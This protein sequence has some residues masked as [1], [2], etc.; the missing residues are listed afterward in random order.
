MKT[1]LLLIMMLSN[2]G[3]WL[4]G[5]EGRVSVLWTAKSAAVPSELIWELKLG[6]TRLDGARVAIGPNDSPVVKIICPE[7]RAK[8][9]LQWNWRLVQ[10][11][12]GREIEKGSEKITAYPATLTGAWAELLKDKRIIVIDRPAGIPA[13]LQLAKIKFTRLD[14][15]AKLQTAVADIILVGPD[16]F[17]AKLFEQDSLQAHL[18][19]GTAVAVFRQMHS[20]TLL[21]MD[22]IPR[23]LPDKFEWPTDE[24]VLRGL[25]SETLLSWE[26]GWSRDPMK[27][28]V[29]SLRVPENELTTAVVNW[30]TRHQDAGV[31][32]LKKPNM[33]VDSLLVSRSG[34]KGG[35]GRLVL[36][37]MPIDD[38]MTDPRSQIFFG[39]LLDVLISPAAPPPVRA[40][41]PPAALRPRSTITISPGDSQ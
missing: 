15:P 7:V 34:G 28:E 16:V 1:A 12:D 26:R 13:L 27:K 22:L 32:L 24:P 14:D 19:A 33:A 4:S 11:Q 38:W 8:V 39:N 17:Q 6:D 37:Q 21:G 20:K 18:S 36:C 3:H 2:E 10:K 40:P 41:L 30:P 9:S 23:S 35:P 25:D 29:R 5:A 31:D